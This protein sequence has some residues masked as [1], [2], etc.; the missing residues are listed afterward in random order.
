MT[1]MVWEKRFTAAVAREGAPN[2]QFA[3]QHRDL[4]ARGATLEK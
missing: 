4:A 2:R 3:P 1:Q